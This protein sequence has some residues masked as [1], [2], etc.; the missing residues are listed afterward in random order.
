[1]MKPLNLFV[2]SL[3]AITALLQTGCTQNDRKSTKTGTV[4]TTALTE[5]KQLSTASAALIAAEK[6]LG[7]AQAHPN[8][9][10][11]KSGRGVAY[12][13]Q[14]AGNARIVHNGQP[15]RLYKLVG[16]IAISRDGSKVAYVAHVDDKFK[17]IVADGQEGPLFLDFGM[18]FFTPDGKYVVYTGTEGNEDRLIIN[19]KVHYGLKVSKEFLLS[20]DSR[21]VAFTDLS[22]KDGRRQFVISDFSLQDKKVFDSCGDSFIVSADQSRIAVDCNEGGLKSIKII[23]FGERKQVANLPLP[24]AGT[25]VRKKFAADNRTFLYATLTADGQRFLHY[26]SRDEKMPTGEEL[27]SDPV[28]LS[29]SSRVGV[30]TGYAYKMRFQTAFPKTAVNDKYYGYISD[31]TASQDGSHY[32]YVAISPGGEERMRLVVDGHEGPLFDKIVS[33]LFSPDGRYLIY[34]ARESGKRFIV[35]SDL[36]GAV[37]R[38]HSEYDMIFQPSFDETGTI[39]SYG[40]LD[41]TELWWKV[42]KL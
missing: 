2:I 16:D 28:L 23:D 19:H 1:M 30:V 32:A 5:S 36:K 14:V 12:I 13:E 38:K 25:I 35:V 26:D 34:R 18:P 41:G 10:F 7:G 29:N 8:I 6:A 22:S 17:K 31:V 24:T 39:M 15:G 11:A 37:V 4:V 42:E 27:M 9:V 33:P 3:I 40:V 21:F 20:A